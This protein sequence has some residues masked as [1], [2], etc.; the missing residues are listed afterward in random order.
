MQGVI[1]FQSASKR[2]I[3]LEMSL[4]KCGADLK[5][6]VSVETGLQKMRLKLISA[7]KVIQDNRTLHEQNIKVK[8]VYTLFMLLPTFYDR[9]SPSQVYCILMPK[10]VK[11]FFEMSR[12]C[13]NTYM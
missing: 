2:V 7:G 8:Y 11:T 9:I 5:Q 3:S 1:W 6:A 13:Q 12:G 10:H 4:D